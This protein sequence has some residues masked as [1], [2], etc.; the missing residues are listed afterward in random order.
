[1]DE[2][3]L[4][5]EA[6]IKDIKA[7]MSDISESMKN[8][9][10]SSAGDKFETGREMMQI[11]LSKQQA[12]LNKQLELKKDLSQI[13][14]NKTYTAVEFGSLVCT[15]KGIY[16]MVFAHGKLKLDHKDY[17]I[18]SMASPIG[19]ALK[20]AKEGD[21]ISFNQQAFKIEKTL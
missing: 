14:L 17:F 10:K 7:T 20:G 13:N 2:L 11:E 3:S 9:T 4:I 16:F 1:M 12:Q 5:I 18:L 6:K 8:D 21:T 19:Q 15:N